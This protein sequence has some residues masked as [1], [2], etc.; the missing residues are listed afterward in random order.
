MLMTITGK[1]GSGKTTVCDIIKSRYG[2]TVYSA[3]QVQRSHAV[4]FGLST[5]DLNKRMDEHP[6]LDN[7]ID[8]EVREMSIIH[9]GENMIFD[10][11]MAWHFAYDTF[12]IFLNID[13]MEAANRVF[14]HRTS[15]EEHYTD[16]D[17]ACA[18]LIERAAVERKRFIEIYGVDYCD[19]NN[20][21]LVVDTTNRTPDE[22]VSVIMEY[23]NLYSENPEAYG[24]VK[25]V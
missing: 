15:V 1:L 10:S 9:K 4:D 22:V 6:G 11:R 17:D 8:S 25:E 7:K 19:F 23:Y 21:N 20:F 3:G 18:K 13:P 24:P 16:V 14:Y 12:K 2:F 5:L